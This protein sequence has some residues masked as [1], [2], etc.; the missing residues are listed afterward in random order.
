MKSNLV[1]IAVLVVLLL[2]GVGY[3]FISSWLNGS[4]SLPVAAANSGQVAF[5]PTQSVANVAEQT[6]QPTAHAESVNPTRPLDDKTAA[7]LKE[8]YP[9]VIAGR[10]DEALALLSPAIQSNPTDPALYSARSFVYSRQ[11]NTDL[12]RQDLMKAI[13]LGDK[14]SLVKFNLAEIDFTQKNYDAA[15]AGFLALVTD[16]DRGDLASYKVF[17]CD[18]WG[19]HDEDAAKELNVFKIAGSNASYY[20]SN[21]AWDLYHHKIDDARTYLDSANRIYS[22]TK[23]KSTPRA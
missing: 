10:L 7:V 15:R 21:I 8:T 14:S 18:L 5:P 19:G 2:G 16:A 13:D 4:P 20:F 11:G 23:S 12:E 9:L 22:P 3:F 1:T 17:L 6:N